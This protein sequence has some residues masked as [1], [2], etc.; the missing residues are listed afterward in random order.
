MNKQSMMENFPAR[1][2]RSITRE[3][4][5]DVAIKAETSRD[6]RPGIGDITVGMSSGTSGKH[7]IFLVS[8]EE[9]LRWAG[10]LLARTLP[11]SLLKQVLLPWLPPLRIAF[12]LRA[13]SNLYN[14][15][16]S[17]RIDF[18]FHDLMKGIDVAIPALNANPPHALVAPATVLSALAAAK[19]EGR[20]HIQPDHIISVAEVLEP[21]DHD[22]IMQAFQCSP[23]QIYQATEGFLGYTC[24]SGNLHLNE[25]HLHIEKCWLDDEQTRFQPVITDFSRKTQLIV[26]YQLNDILRIAPQPCS[27]GRAETTI[28]AIEGRCDEILWMR[29][30]NSGQPVA[31][32]PDILR[33][34]MM[35]VSP[36]LT[37][38]AVRQSGTCWHIDLLVDGNIDHAKSAVEHA[39]DRLCADLATQ[40]PTLTFG[41]WQPPLPGQKRR[42]LWCESS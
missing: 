19:T 29:G 12:F 22:R 40:P 7:G 25:T 27:C 6:F 8:K 26:R 20:L 4:A 35:L 36:A 42:R 28:A 24:E 34:T 18:A 37:E 3:Q 11:R 30:I 38:Y 31:I 13:N 21:E 41:L 9:R 10:I 39:I 32:Y 23:H 1:N 2:T 14:T 5:L 17:R 33:R 15:L 16:N